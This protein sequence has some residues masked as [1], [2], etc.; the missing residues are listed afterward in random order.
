MSPL[1]SFNFGPAYLSVD[2]FLQLMGKD[3]VTALENQIVHYNV[4]TSMFDVVVS[5]FL[6]YNN[7]FCFKNMIFFQ[8]ASA[9]RFTVLLLFYALLYINHWVVIAVS[10]FYQEIFS[11]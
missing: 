2:I 5:C 1:F 7:F 8:M 10:I 11:V 3:I 9:C 6:W 4:H